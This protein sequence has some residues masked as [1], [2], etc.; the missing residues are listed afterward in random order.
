MLTLDTVLDAMRSAEPWSRLDELIR[1]EL[2]AGR[3]TWQIEQELR[4]IADEAWKAP[5]LTEDGEDA[6]GDTLDALAGTCRSDRCY[7]DQPNVTLP[8]E[9][10]IVGL[11]RWG[12]V[13]FAVRCAKRVL[14]RLKVN[15][16]IMPEEM[17]V[18]SATVVA[19]EKV[20]A[21]RGEHD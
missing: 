15:R 19:V 12:R 10:E 6:L 7:R 3:T 4:P 16:D 9:K 13:A 14:Q 5:N 11:P 18:A 20:S 21:G 17:A 2:A 8:T 1:A